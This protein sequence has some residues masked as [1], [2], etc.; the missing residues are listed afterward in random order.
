MDS[1][2]MR[3]TPLKVLPDISDAVARY[4]ALGFHG[5]TV[6]RGACV[7]M[8]AGQTNVVLVSDTFMRGDF[9]AEHVA[10]LIGR[11]I[12]YIHV[13]SVEHARA[14]LPDGARVL[15]DVE[16]RAGTREVLID[17]RDDLFI[18]AEKPPT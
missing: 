10:R 2:V 18:L 6:E 11:T 13:P 16:T 3:V 9:D 17:D 8:R 15:Q 5:T 7:G 4:E 1:S 14:R 12:D